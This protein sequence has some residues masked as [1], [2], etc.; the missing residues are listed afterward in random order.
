MHCRGPQRLFCRFNH[1]LRH[2]GADMHAQGGGGGLQQRGVSCVLQLPSPPGPFPSWILVWHSCTRPVALPSCAPPRPLQRPCHVSMQGDV[3]GACVS[4]FTC[5]CGSRIRSP[6]I[7]NHIRRIQD[8]IGRL[9]LL[10]AKKGGLLSRVPFVEIPVH[11]ISSAPILTAGH[12]LKER[13]KLPKH[14]LSK[15]SFGRPLPWLRGCTLK[16]AHET[17]AELSNTTHNAC[18]RPAEIRKL[19][20][21]VAPKHH[22]TRS[23]QTAQA[24][25]CWTFVVVPLL[26][27]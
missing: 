23:Y 26:C 21:M 6:S 16:N 18:L 10:C 17:Q 24:L 20:G 4:L 13:H 11:R 27:W 12:G 1:I 19:V 15:T 25:E 5:A 22:H 2:A 8:I 9:I 7:G 3:G 14:A